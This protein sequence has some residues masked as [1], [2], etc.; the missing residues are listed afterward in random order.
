MELKGKEVLVL[1]LARTGMECARFLAEH[2]AKVR[3]TD[4]RSEQ[5]L[6]HG[7]ESLRE[8]PIQYLSG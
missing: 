6:K 5:D 1:G 2:G 7:M 4:L 3:V 8:L